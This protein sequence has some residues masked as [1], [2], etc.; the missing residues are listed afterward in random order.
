MINLFIIIA[1]FLHAYYMV[2]LLLINIKK[3]LLQSNKLR[4]YYYL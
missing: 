2:G 3:K 4:Y 1:F